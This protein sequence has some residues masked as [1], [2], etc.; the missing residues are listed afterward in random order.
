MSLRKRS[1]RSKFTQPPFTNIL[2]R[3][4][5]GGSKF[6]QPP[7]TNILRREVGG[8]QICTAPLYKYSKILIMI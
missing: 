5:G 2:R 7:F 4:V 1:R 6:T 3:E 8:E